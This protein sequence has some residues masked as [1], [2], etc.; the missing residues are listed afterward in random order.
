[1]SPNTSDKGLEVDSRI[2]RTDDGKI[3][4]FTDFDIYNLRDESLH[5][6]N[7]YEFFSIFHLKKKPRTQKKTSHLGRRR[8]MKFNFIDS[9]K[10]IPDNWHLEERFKLVIIQMIGKKPPPSITLPPEENSKE[11][12]FWLKRA[13]LHVRFYALILFPWSLKKTFSDSQR[14]NNKNSSLGG[15]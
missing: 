10:V 7:I 3:M 12:K 13:K 14:R 4:H 1:M 6:M 2:D 11:F 5:M 9:G 15:H 8:A